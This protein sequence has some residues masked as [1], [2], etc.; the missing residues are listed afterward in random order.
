[1]KIIKNIL[2]A[3]ALFVLTMSVL[4]VVFVSFNPVKTFQ[5]LKVM[6]GSME[7]ALKTG[8][9]AFVKQTNPLNLKE[10]DIVSYSLKNSPLVTHRIIKV[11]TNAKELSFITKG[12]ANKTAD[13]DS[14]SSSDI[15][16]KVI[17]SIPFLGYLANWTRTPVGFILLIIIPAVLIILNEIFSMHKAVKDEIKKKVNENKEPLLLSFFIV[18][19]A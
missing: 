5:I 9:V 3:F 8:S 7:P 10:G 16:G 12:D 1:M 13:V 15:K 6:S 14:I 4:V 19:A 2:I 11:N 17:F 18:T